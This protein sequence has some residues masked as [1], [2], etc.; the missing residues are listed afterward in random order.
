M[1]KETPFTPNIPTSVLGDISGITPYGL[2]IED[3]LNIKLQ[4]HA[5]DIQMT[6]DN[7]LKNKKNYEGIVKRLEKVHGI[8]RNS[9]LAILNNQHTLKAII[10]K[11]IAL[12]GAESSRGSRGVLLKSVITAG[13]Q[14]NLDLPQTNYITALEK[15]YRQTPQKG[16][17]TASLRTMGN[18][19]FPAP[20]EFHKAINEGFGNIGN[21]NIKSFAM[22]KLFT[23]V[24]NPDILK[25]QIMPPK[26]T[27]LQNNAT[28]YDPNRQKLYIYNKG[29]GAAAGALTELDLGHMVNGIISEQAEDA[30]AAGRKNLFPVKEFLNRDGKIDLKKMEKAYGAEINKQVNQALDSYGLEI[31]D[32]KDMKAK[33]FTLKHL[34]NNIYDVIEENL[35]KDIANDILGHKGDFHMGLHYTVDRTARRADLGKLKSV[36]L[37]AKLFLEDILYSVSDDGQIRIPENRGLPPRSFLKEHGYLKAIKE[38]AKKKWGSIALVDGDPKDANKIK[39]FYAQSTSE[40][41]AMGKSEVKAQINSFR[42]SMSNLTEVLGNEFKSIKRQI[43]IL[44]E[45][46]EELK[47]LKGNKADLQRTFL[48]KQYKKIVRQVEKIRKALPE[49]L[50]PTIRTAAGDVDHRKRTNSMTNWIN[51]N[52]VNKQNIKK[53]AMIAAGILG[54]G[55]VKAAE[56]GADLAIEAFMTSNIGTVLEN[57]PEDIPDE[58]LLNMLQEGFS[59]AAGKESTDSMIGS[60]IERRIKESEDVAEQYSFAEGSGEG[61]SEKA[62]K[63]KEGF[64]PKVEQ[65]Y[66]ERDITDV[67]SIPDEPESLRDIEKDTERQ[68]DPQKFKIESLEEE[69]ESEEGD[70][71]MEYEG[72]LTPKEPN[73]MEQLQDYRSR[74]QSFLN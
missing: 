18:F 33:P 66:L 39:G 31:I 65:A 64:L 42:E 53:G 11:E 61:L 69:M 74:R 17:N 29:K 16:F 27:S 70:L 28:Y 45:K 3:A 58:Q 26:G 30:L 48:G 72:F 15:A 10:E 68:R 54:S 20:W 67:T 35:G 22:I 25:L 4:N 7:K 50:Q 47:N 9:D 14:S 13:L 23:G 52:I 44:S 49:G 19:R 21:K 24:R 60:E 8:P 56:Y 43:K 2:T 59:T 41:V 5:D 62:V 57:N 73:V 36:D 38:L 37:F 40:A 51:K 46:T 55:K 34:R 71:M 12:G 1:V 63:W 6:D 32:K